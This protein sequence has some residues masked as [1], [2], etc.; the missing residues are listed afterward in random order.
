MQFNQFCYTT[1]YLLWNSWCYKTQFNAEG[2]QDSWFLFHEHCNTLSTASCS[3][4]SWDPFC[5]AWF[6]RLPWTWT[7]MQHAI[8]DIKLR[9]SKQIRT[10]LF[11]KKIKQKKPTKKAF[12]HHYNHIH[13]VHRTAKHTA[14]WQAQQKLTL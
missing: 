5:I 10:I 4:T 6:Q 9:T 8:G 3:R 11:K 7:D 13:I 2:Y 14:A 12:T 1:M